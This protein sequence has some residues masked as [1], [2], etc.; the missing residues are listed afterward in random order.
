MRSWSMHRRLLLT[1]TGL[2]G[3]LWVAGVT[4]SAFVMRHEIDEVF[5][6]ALQET[7]QRILPLAYR[8]L[9]ERRDR[10]R[11][12]DEEDGD[13]HRA[14]TS[15]SDDHKEYI[16]YQ[17]RN[18][19]GAV[20]L[21]SH[22]AP[23]VAFGAPL[24][25]GHFDDGA[26]RYFTEWSS[27]RSIAIQVA[28]LPEERARA[29]QTLWL[30]HL[31]PL[32]IVL[33]LAALIIGLTVRR[34]MR[35][36]R[37]LREELKARDGSNLAAISGDGLPVELTPVVSDVNRLLV[38]LSAALE[39]ERAFASNSAHELRNP[40]AAA[41]AQATLLVDGAATD[42]QR[43]RGH[44]LLTSLTTLGRRIE[45]LLQLARAE[46]GMALA[47]SSFALDDLVRLLVTDWSRKPNARGRLVFLDEAVQ[48]PLV[49]TAN[50][51]A[52]G[53]AIQNLID[54]AA[55]HSPSGSEVVVRLGPGPEV[56]I[57]NAGPVVPA[58]ELRRLKDRFQRAST[59]ARE[60]SG[61]GLYIADTIA[62]QSGAELT[63]YSPA[64]GTNE[65]FEAVLKW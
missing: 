11:D 34:A 44:H 65:G 32:G 39:A 3:A 22:N 40:I 63:L 35:P 4:T 56:S 45:T 48:R 16:L 41:Q 13:E 52:I 20:L 46:S 64:R 7:A 30:G 43:Q 12:E 54:N 8:D 1:L 26:R 53:I 2:I 14:E 15:T 17:V 58:E 51:D 28:E 21:R 37:R 5:D 31:V 62:R 61:L 38:R 49:V 57:R 33:P 18:A 36:V 29:I 59:G 47:K 9:R 10:D 42:D 55:K 24:T 23:A 50:E 25:R 19:S 60:G 6:S 27:D